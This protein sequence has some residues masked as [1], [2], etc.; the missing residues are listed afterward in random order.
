MCLRP[1]RNQPTSIK[2]V[3]QPFVLVHHIVVIRLKKIKPLCDMG[4]RS[5]SLQEAPLL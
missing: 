5:V 1:L 3:A 2:L 4:T